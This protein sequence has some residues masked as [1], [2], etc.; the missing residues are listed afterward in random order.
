MPEDTTMAPPQVSPTIL[1]GVIAAIGNQI[2][3]KA[4]DLIYNS[5]IPDSNW[6]DNNVTILKDIDNLS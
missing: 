5:K 2:L 4:N 1:S 6:V 3:Y